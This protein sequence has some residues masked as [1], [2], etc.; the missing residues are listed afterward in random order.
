MTKI[1]TIN[2]DRHV[3]WSECTPEQQSECDF[4]MSTLMAALGYEALPHYMVDLE[5]GHSREYESPKNAPTTPYSS[6]KSD[7]IYLPPNEC[8]G[9]LNASTRDLGYTQEPR[10]S[11]DL[12]KEFMLSLQRKN[13][14]PK[15]KTKA[16]KAKEAASDGH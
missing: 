11:V 8:L 5:H 14:K 10:S 6:I 2:D 12:E 3:D 16:Q 1:A 4:I 7:Y 15:A 9:G 13:T